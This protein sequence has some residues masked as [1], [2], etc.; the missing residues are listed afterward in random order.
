MSL[1][2]PGC[3]DRAHLLGL[4]TDAQ[5]VRD[6]IALQGARLEETANDPALPEDIR[7]AHADAAD[8]LTD[9][10]GDLDTAIAALDQLLATEQNPED[11]WNAVAGP[12]IPALPEPLRSPVLLLGAL[13]V[14]LARAAQLKRAAGSIARGIAKAAEKDD[15]F[16]SVFNRHADTFRAVQTP[17]AKRIIDERVRPGFM[18][19][20]PL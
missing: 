15:E 19:R 20:L 8:A 18:L 6:E 2:A 9:R 17:A 1:A 3:I 4:R 10:L 5:S 7:R 16:R 11:L 12:L 13:G 14:S